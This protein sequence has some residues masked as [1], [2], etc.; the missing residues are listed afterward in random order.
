MITSGNAKITLTLL[1][2]AKLTLMD[3]VGAKMICLYGSDSKTL[4]FA[5]L[6]IFHALIYSFKNLCIRDSN[7]LEPD[8]AIHYVRLDLGPKKKSSL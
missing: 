7:S 1:E 6:E 2:N 8:Q 3:T 5:Y 4:T